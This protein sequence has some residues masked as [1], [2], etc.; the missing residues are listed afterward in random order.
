MQMSGS[1][2]HADK[3]LSMCA[4]YLLIADIINQA[5]NQYSPFGMRGPQCDVGFCFTRHPLRKFCTE[6]PKHELN[7]RHQELVQEKDEQRENVCRKYCIDLYCLLSHIGVVESCWS[8]VRSRNS[9]P[10]GD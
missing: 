7:D 6:T 4:D 5:Q 1:P 2:M 8:L 10:T 3:S 9:F